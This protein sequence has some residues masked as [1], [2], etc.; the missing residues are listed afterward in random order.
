[1][2]D[3]G[4]LGFLEAKAWMVMS[5]EMPVEHEFATVLGRGRNGEQC[6]GLLPKREKKGRLA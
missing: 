4:K 1:M 3:S 6:W 2:W 5:S